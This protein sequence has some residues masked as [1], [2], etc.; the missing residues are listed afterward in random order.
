MIKSVV[1]FLLVIGVLTGIVLPKSSV[2]LAELG[3]I[4]GQVLVICTGDGLQTLIL[5]ADG[6]PVEVTHNAHQCLLVHATDTATAILP[7]PIRMDLVQGGVKSRLTA[8]GPR[9]VP[10]LDARPRAPPKA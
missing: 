10:G 1:R 8:K 4:R 9:Q 7:S 6:T 3:L 2:V 5:N